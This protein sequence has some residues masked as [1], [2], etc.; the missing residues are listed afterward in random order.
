[1][2]ISDSCDPGL[3]VWFSEFVGEGEGE[4]AGLTVPALRMQSGEAKLAVRRRG[5]GRT[6]NLLARA[7]GPFFNQAAGGNGAAN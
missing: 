5:V 1:M 6:E 2:T 3:P 4:F 7:I